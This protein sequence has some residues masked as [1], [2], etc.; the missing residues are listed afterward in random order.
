MLWVPMP[1][2]ADPLPYGHI[3]ADTLL[4]S[5]CKPGILG[6]IINQTWT[7]VCNLAVVALQ[8]QND[9]SQLAAVCKQTSPE[10]CYLAA[11][12]M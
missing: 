9:G 2:H 10:I 4:A 6:A 5:A 7:G 1:D 12:V 3:T 11:E 8:L